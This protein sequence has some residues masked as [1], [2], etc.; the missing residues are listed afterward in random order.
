[1]EVDS[2]CAYPSIL[3]FQIEDRKYEVRDEYPWKPTACS[4][5]KSFDHPND[6]CGSNPTPK[7]KKKWVPKAKTATSD[8]LVNVRIL[9]TTSW[10]MHMIF[11]QKLFLLY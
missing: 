5:C 10:R 9:L 11:L 2:N 6:K 4:Y 1:M 8:A 7:Y 3:P